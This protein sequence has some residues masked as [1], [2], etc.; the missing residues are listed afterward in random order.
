MSRTLTA[1]LAVATTAGSGAFAPAADAAEPVEDRTVTTVRIQ[2]GTLPKGVPTAHP[3]LVDTTIRD[4]KFR[5]H[6]RVLERYKY[7]GMTAKV[8]KGYLVTGSRTG[9]S[10]DLWYVPRRGPAKRMR[11]G[12]YDLYQVSPSGRYAA[13][14]DIWGKRD[15]LRIRTIP[16]DKTIARRTAPWIDVLGMRGP[17]ALLNV[18]KQ[19]REW[20]AWLRPKAD[21]LRHVVERAGWWASARHNRLLTDEPRAKGGFAMVR[22][23]KPNKVLWRRGMRGRT[24]S[25]ISP[26]GRFLV[27]PMYDG[28]SY[29]RTIGLEVRRIR[30]GR[31]VRRFRAK[32]FGWDLSWVGKH[33]FLIA[34]E[35]RTRT[36]LVR[37]GVVGSCKRAGKS[38]RTRLGMS[39]DQSLGISL[40]SSRRVDGV[41]GEARDRTRGL[42]L[43]P[44]S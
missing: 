28:T 26:D 35:G 27:A 20:V 24:P 40:A 31:L 2:P 1:L 15:E 14:T 23:D 19:R 22:L 17:R 43:T 29:F 38:V 42:P 30:D 41:S 37:C 8:H 33:R 4:G 3:R 32:E 39:P 21:S 25:W 44:T 13:V 16:G 34:A 18:T 9:R 10:A 6:V 36:A 11:L 5:K 12:K 7:T